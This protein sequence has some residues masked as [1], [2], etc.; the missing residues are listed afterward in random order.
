MADDLAHEIKNP[1]NSM[2]IN[3]EVLR[4]KVEKGAT[5]AA[6]ER[7]AVLEHEIRRLHGL[8]E[9]LLR[10]L[11]PTR[12]REATTSMAQALEELQPV[13]ELRAR[14][15]RIEFSSI[16]LLADAFTPVPA[17]ALRFSLLMVAELVLDL[18]GATGSAM[19]LTADPQPGEI[20]VRIGYLGDASVLRSAALLHGEGS[21]SLR[22]IPAAA[23]LLEP[24]GG[25]V[26]VEAA[27]PRPAVL[28][29]VPRVQ[30]M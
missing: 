17:D 7:A 30:F 11:R 22:G 5:D 23:A 20:Q 19:W 13:V 3:L 18:A 15:A 26:D 1:L 28:I 29:R 24:T 27:G 14:L 16:G 4:S 2:V 6:L 25:R 21:D 12:D 9:A 8:V 10:L